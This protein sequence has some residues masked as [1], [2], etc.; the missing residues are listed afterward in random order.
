MPQPNHQIQEFDKK[1][2]KCVYGKEPGHF[3]SECKKL[4]V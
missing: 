2:I 1:D 4:T 3:I